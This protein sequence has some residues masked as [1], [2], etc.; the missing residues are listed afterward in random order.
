MEIGFLSILVIQ[1]TVIF[2][3]IIL[4]TYTECSRPPDQTPFLKSQILRLCEK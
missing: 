3:D 1:L 4:T 2:I